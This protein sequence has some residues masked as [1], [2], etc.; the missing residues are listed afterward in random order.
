MHELQTM[1]SRTQRHR[2]A[3]PYATFLQTSSSQLPRSTRRFGQ[4]DAWYK[5]VIIGAGIAGVSAAEAMCGASPQ[6]R[7]STL[8]AAESSLPYYRLNLTRYLA[9]EITPRPVLPAYR[10]SG[11]A[12][13]VLSS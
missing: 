9:W 2:R 1:L 8:L 13:T 5:A 4:P 6:A 10:G 7:T 12:R 11:T 3:A